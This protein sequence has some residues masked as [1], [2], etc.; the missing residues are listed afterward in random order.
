MQFHVSY[1]YFRSADYEYINKELSDVDWFKEFLNCDCDTNADKFYCIIINLIDKYV[2][3]KVSS[4]S[5]KFPKWFSKEL[6]ECIREKNNAHWEFK[7]SEDDNDYIEFKR[8]RTISIR[9]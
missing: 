3:T 6:R 4:S 1:K 7:L 9:K 8:L 2:C 5:T